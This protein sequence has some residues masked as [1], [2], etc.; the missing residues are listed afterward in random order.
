MIIIIIKTTTITIM[1]MII[2]ILIITIIKQNDTNKKIIMKIII[3]WN[4]TIIAKE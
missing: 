1:I 2:I 4:E 3:K